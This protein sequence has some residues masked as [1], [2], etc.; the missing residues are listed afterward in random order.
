VLH[1]VRQTVEG[2]AH[3]RRKDDPLVS[4]SVA[5][6]HLLARRVEVAVRLVRRNVSVLLGKLAEKGGAQ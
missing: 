4:V 2:W 5:D 3:L 6:L 1:A